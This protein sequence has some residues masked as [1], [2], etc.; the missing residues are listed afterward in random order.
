MLEYSDYILTC[1]DI[2]MFN[3]SPLGIPFKVDCRF[4]NGELDKNIDYIFL[5]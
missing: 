5:N 2:F 3:N 4:I 1:V